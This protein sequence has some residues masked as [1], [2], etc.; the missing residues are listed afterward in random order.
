MKKAL[1]LLLVLFFTCL[2][3]LFA[4][5]K[6]TPSENQEQT[7]FFYT[8]LGQAFNF[9]DLVIIVTGARIEYLN[10]AR[11]VKPAKFEPDES[12]MPIFAVNYILIN[13]TE[14]KKLE[15]AKPFD[16]EL[17]DEFGN[18]YKVITPHANKKNN[19][20]PEASLY[21]GATKEGTVY[22]EAPVKI[23]QT[24]SLTID[25]ANIG[26]PQKLKIHI[27]STKIK[28]QM[29]AKIDLAELA[30]ITESS[31]EKAVNSRSHGRNFYITNPAA[32]AQVLPGD[33]VHL[34]VQVNKNISKP[35]TVFIVTPFKVLEDASAA[36]GYNIQIPENQP[37]GPITVVVIGKWLNPAEHILSDSVTFHVVDKSEQCLKDCWAKV[38]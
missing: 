37:K 13:N 18:R 35:G 2:G 10:Q 6:V 32:Q 17:T 26:I 38:K 27:P 30:D 11:L 36:L 20:W 22:F 24:L 28:R 16:F 25:A 31:N 21:P 14:T 9:E 34:Q 5:E 15:L 1:S 12:A 23:S 4:Q 29:S 8:H 19:A 3:Q 7:G 33:T